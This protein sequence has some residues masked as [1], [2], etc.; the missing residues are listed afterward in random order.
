MRNILFEFQGHYYTILCEKVC[1]RSF[2]FNETPSFE[3]NTE[4]HPRP[5]M[6][7]Q[8]ECD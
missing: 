4:P 5:D 7:P 6:K 3:H 1:T 2:M 8:E